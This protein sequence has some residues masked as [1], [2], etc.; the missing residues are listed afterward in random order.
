VAHRAHR[1]A[2]DVTSVKCVTPMVVSR[3]CHR[4]DVNVN[5][6]V[7]VND[8]VNF[9]FNVSI[10]SSTSTSERFI[11]GARGSSRSSNALISLLLS[12]CIACSGRRHVGKQRPCSE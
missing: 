9:N 5:V 1:V 11:E 4:G 2:L 12:W 8:V 6:N 3:I 7:N 10:N